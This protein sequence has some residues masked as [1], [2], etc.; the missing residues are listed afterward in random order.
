MKT[1]FLPMLGAAALLLGSRE[2]A[3]AEHA[4][5][6]DVQKEG[7]EPQWFQV[8]DSDKA[9]RNAVHQARRTVDVFI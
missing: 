2:L 7:A 5:A 1:T 8:N 6:R 4:V 9:M 3:N